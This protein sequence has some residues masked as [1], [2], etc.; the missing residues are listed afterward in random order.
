MERIPAIA[1]LNA[2]N[3]MQIPCRGHAS[4]NHVSSTS[5]CCCTSHH[6]LSPRL[7]MRRGGGAVG[8]SLGASVSM[9][10][11][12]AERSPDTIVL[13][14]PCCC[15][16]KSA[17]S[18]HLRPLLCTCAGLNI[19]TRFLSAVL[20]DCTLG[21]AP[22]HARAAGTTASGRHQF[23]TFARRRGDSLGRIPYFATNAASCS[24]S[25]CNTGGFAAAM[26]SLCTLPPLCRAR[27]SSR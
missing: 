2:V 21:H 17:L 12:G 22:Y 15:S 5:Q 10:C 8:D 24:S 18:K 23:E 27:P 14:L 25:I 16:A 20:I 26:F 3:H 19:K 4:S 1:I 6:P 7:D 13:S 9:G 11:S